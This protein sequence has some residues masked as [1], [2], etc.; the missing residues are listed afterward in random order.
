[1]TMPAFR[2][3][4]R[5]GVSASAS[6]AETAIGVHALGDEILNHLDLLSGIGNSRTGEHRVHAKLFASLDHAGTSGLKI[7]NANLL[8]A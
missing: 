2:A 6:F 7:R 1:M 5:T 3:C 4:V 8:Q